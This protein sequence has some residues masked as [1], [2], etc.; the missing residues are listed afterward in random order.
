MVC[1]KWVLVPVLIFL[2]QIPSILAIS[3][4]QH[5]VDGNKVTISYQGTPPFWINIRPDTDIGQAGGYLWANIYSNPFSYDMSFAINPSGS[6][7]YGV[8]DTDW[9]GTNLFN[10]ANTPSCI[11]STKPRETICKNGVCKLVVSNDA[12]CSDVNR[13]KDKI[14]VLMMKGSI[15]ED[16]SLKQKID[17]F[18]Q[19]IKS[20]V[21]ID[22][23]GITYFDGKNSDELDA[24]IEKIYCNQ[25]VGYVIL[26]GEEFE[27]FIK[28]NDDK[29]ITQYANWNGEFTNV[30]KKRYTFE[31]GIQE[32]NPDFIC[33]DVI[34]SW[35]LPPM[36]YQKKLSNNERINFVSKTIDTYTKYHLNTDN[37][38]SN[39]KGHLHI[40]WDVNT[41]GDTQFTTP[42][43][44]NSNTIWVL[45][46][47]HEKI[48][49]LIKN[50]YKFFSFF[51]HGWPTSLTIGV[52]PNLTTDPNL[53]S[54]TVDEFK[55][56]KIDNLALIAYTG[57]AC[58]TGWVSWNEIYNTCCWPQNFMDA[59]IWAQFSGFADSGVTPILEPPFVGQKIREVYGGYMLFGDPT[60]H[61][62]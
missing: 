2:L 37:I 34:I 21:K 56:M 7:Y 20:D 13:N 3:N 49:E 12:V 40:Q 14:T 32:N 39:F 54:T 35:I 5:S 31:N 24:F 36:P 57:T 18:L 38:L 48:S 1:I 41:L 43:Y 23:I 17:Y 47:E 15:Y 61:I 19:S 50:H 59:G 25:D 30:G 52:T 29:Y 27:Q 9:S 58:N 8:K 46:T 11:G 60:A 6:F 16:S 51:V 42:L 53:V 45:N 33:K 26:I 22:N 62:N 10:F 28:S 4:V 55:D 44:V